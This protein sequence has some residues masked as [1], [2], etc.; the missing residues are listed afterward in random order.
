VGLA[1]SVTAAQKTALRLVEFNLHVA[2][3]AHRS[4]YEGLLGGEKLARALLDGEGTLLARVEPQ[5]SGWLLRDSGLAAQMDWQM[6]EPQKRVWL[7]DRPELERLAIELALAMHREW[8]VQIIDSV[9]LRA[10]SGVVGEA[11]RFVIEE[12]PA[13]C[14]HYQAAA[15]S[16]DGDLRPDLG[17][18]LKIH[19]ARTLFA[20]LDPA[21]RAV[22]GRA[23]FF[24]ERSR[25]IGEVPPLEPT[26]RQRALDLIIERLIPRRFPEWAWCF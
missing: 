19:G 10:L 15:I 7:L 2:R 24:F 1:G 23:Q 3:Y 25:V 14:F 20:L 26:L 8:L 13:G 18:E 5:I 11:L 12:V 4:W 6:E 22:R 16:F 21:W 9:R 17:T